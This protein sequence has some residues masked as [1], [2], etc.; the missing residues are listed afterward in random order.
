ML[1]TEQS[2]VSARNQT[3]I[4]WLSILQPSYYTSYSYTTLVSLV[5]VLLRIAARMNAFLSLLCSHEHTAGNTAQ[6]EIS[7][8]HRKHEH[9]SNIKNVQNIF[10]FSP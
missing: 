7:V 1:W 5:Q 9:Y 8:L 2:I 4:P 6:H 3:P 10:V